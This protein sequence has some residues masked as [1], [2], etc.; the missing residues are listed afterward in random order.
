MDSRVAHLSD[1]TAL[2]HLGLFKCK[3]VTNSGI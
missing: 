1:L 3:K 2:Q